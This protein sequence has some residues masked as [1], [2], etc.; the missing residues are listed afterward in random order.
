MCFLI[1]NKIN[2]QETLATPRGYILDFRHY[3]ITSPRGWRM[4]SRFR[5]E[6]YTIGNLTLVALSGDERE[7]QAL[8]NDDEEIPSL[9][10][11]SNSWPRSRKNNNRLSRWAHLLAK[12][13][14]INYLT[15]MLHT[16]KL[17]IWPRLEGLI[18]SSERCRTVLFDVSQ[19]AISNLKSQIS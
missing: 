15:E 14:L 18:I 4:S 19:E 11:N 5:K 8:G 2:F 12:G 17:M 6:A 7:A 9:S 1:K 10:F 13:S 16:W 3:Y